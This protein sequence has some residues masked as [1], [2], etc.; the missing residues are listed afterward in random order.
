M[1]FV[2]KVE[3]LSKNFGRVQAVKGVS[4]SVEKGEIFG[5]I[6]PNGAGKTTTLEMIEGILKPDSGS[7]DVLGLTPNRQ[8]QQ[9]NQQI[10]VQFQSASIQKKMKVKEALDLFAAFYPGEARK[11]Q[12][13]EMLGLEEKMNV[14]F[15]NLSGGWKQR[16]TLALATLHQ[17]EIV[18]LDEPSM[19]LDPHARRELWTLIRK[20]RDQGSTIVLTTHYMEEAEQLCDRVAMI[21]SGEL[22]ALDRPSALLEKS[23]GQ[24]ITFQSRDIPYVK[25]RSIP[26]VVKVDKE[27]DTFKVYSDDLQLTSYHIFTYCHQENLS[28]M[29]FQF[30]KGTLE[31]LFVHYLEKEEAE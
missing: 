14:R 9:L 24:L 8:L 7:I 2:I 29:H 22:R 13:V 18:F 5:I 28:L 26:G 4:F 27:D 19:G 31:D 3:S 25:L 15:E 17:P 30:A 20:L 11:A 16:V 12:L 1:T 23:G 21:Y 10:G 6:G